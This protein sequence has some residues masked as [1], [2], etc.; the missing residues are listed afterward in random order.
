MRLPMQAVPV[1]RAIVGY[2][3]TGVGGR[4]A[5]LSSLCSPSNGV[6]ASAESG[7][8]PNGF[9]D[10]LKDIGHAVGTGIDIVKTVGPMFGLP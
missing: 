7:V 4:D 8:G 1:Q 6:V 5:A 2:S 10:V 9:F 3:R